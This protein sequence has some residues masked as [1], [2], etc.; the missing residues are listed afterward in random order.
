MSKCAAGRRA[1]PQPLTARTHPPSPALLSR[2]PQNGMA[3]I[4][5]DLALL[6]QLEYL[7][8]TNNGLLGPSVRKILDAL[9]NLVTV[10][11]LHA[12]PRS[13]HHRASC[14]VRLLPL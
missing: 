1:L 2:L 10:R 11:A 14:L 12:G 6:S 7:I 8:L 5:P 4:L 9:P 3:G 13:P